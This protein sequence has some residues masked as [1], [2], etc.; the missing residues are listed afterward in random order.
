LRYIFKQIEEGDGWKAGGEEEEEEVKEG[1][2]SRPHNLPVFL[3]HAVWVV[4]QILCNLSVIPSKFITFK[5][6]KSSYNFNDLW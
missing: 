4:F 1:G 2:G 5:S 3:L 6:L